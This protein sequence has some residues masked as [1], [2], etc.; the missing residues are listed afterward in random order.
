MIRN[1]SFFNTKTGTGG[2]TSSCFYLTAISFIAITTIIG[3]S[4][5]ALRPTQEMSDTAA[6]IKAAREVQAEILAPEL[7]RQANEFFFKAK[8]EYK[9][10]NFREA[11]EY[12][13]KSRRFAEQAEFEAIRNGADRVE[14]TALTPLANETTGPPPTTAPPA[15]KPEPYEYPNPTGTPYETYEKQQQ[16]SPT[17]PAPTPISSTP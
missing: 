14:D 1:N 7:Y 9:F 12:A 16:A 3:C 4:V 10:K 15:P 6:A 5:F 8:N 13:E 17:A 2:K 11:K